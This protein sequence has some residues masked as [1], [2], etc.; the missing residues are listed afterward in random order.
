MISPERL[1][2]YPFFGNFPHKNLVQLADIA[3]EMIVHPG[4]IIF[5]EGE[6]IDHIYLIESGAVGLSIAIPA[7][8]VTHSVSDQ[9]T[10]KLETEEIV[11]SALDRGDVFGWSGLVP[12][13][14][15]T[16]T[17]RALTESHLLAFD[18]DQLRDLFRED[19][20]FG[21]IMMMKIGQVIRQRFED[22]HM[23]IL[24]DKVSNLPEP[25]PS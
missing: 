25:T 14:H 7:R 22:L 24:A 8:G 23:E 21:Y 18:C 10:G 19:C 20:R 3:E 11:I 5:R 9:L 17:A 1:R 2:F 16:A 12:P 4:D 13:H 15:S 6:E